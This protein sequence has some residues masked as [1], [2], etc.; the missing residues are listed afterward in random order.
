MYAA[1]PIASEASSAADTA[2]LADGDVVEQGPTALGPV[3]VDDDAHHAA[4]AGGHDLQGVQLEPEAL[5]DR[6]HDGLDRCVLHR[7]APP[8]DPVVSRSCLGASSAR[9]PR[10]SRGGVENLRRA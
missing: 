10:P 1:W 5:Q 2:W 6:A 8:L 3:A 9:R 7:V 4:L